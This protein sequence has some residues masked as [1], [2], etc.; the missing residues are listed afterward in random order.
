[1]A[2]GRQKLVVPDYDLQEAVELVE[3][4]GPFPNRGKLHEAVAETAWGKKIGIS[5]SAV[6]L[7]IKEYATMLKTPLGRRGR[8]KGQVVVKTGVTF[9][10]PMSDWI[11]DTASKGRNVD[12]D[13]TYRWVLAADKFNWIL[14]RQRQDTD[15]LDSFKKYFAGFRSMFLYMDGIMKLKTPT[16][17]V[18]D[19]LC[20]VLDKS[21]EDDGEDKTPA[22]FGKVI[23]KSLQVNFC[24]HDNIYERVFKTEGSE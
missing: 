22:E 21:I 24:L 6:G 20:Q 15:E 1:M 9:L 2:K 11:T 12:E 18:L 8:Q 23:D 14:A 17:A 3:K 19:K 10:M 16:D 5:P 13:F 7:K 4:D